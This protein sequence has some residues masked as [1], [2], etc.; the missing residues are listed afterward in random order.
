[1]EEFI[2]IQRVIY[3]KFGNFHE[4]FIFTNCV[5]RH[6]CH[7]KNPRLGHDLSTPVNDRVISQGFFL[8]HETKSVSKFFEFTVA[9][10]L[11]EWLAI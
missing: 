8:F 5:K 4:N 7:V 2:S 1:M 9:K 11:D 6:I 3:C 10:C